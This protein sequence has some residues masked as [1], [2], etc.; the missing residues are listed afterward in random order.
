[1]KL[2][3]G[4]R[5][6]A[7]ACLLIGEGSIYLVPSKHKKKNGDVYFTLIPYV[8]FVNTDFEVIDFLEIFVRHFKPT[9]T[10]Y[11]V[12]EHIPLQANHKKS[13]ILSLH[14][15]HGVCSFLKKIRPY[16]FGIKAKEADL[17][18]EFCDSRLNR[19]YLKIGHPGQ[20]GNCCG[21]KPY[22][23]RELEIYKEL[24]ALNHRGREEKLYKEFVA[25]WLL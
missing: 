23:K 14:S 16:L 19:P 6:C 13:K 5:L 4:E 2:T 25:S 20:L 18:V 8:D 11:R 21:K 12:R 22:S 9:A 7:V 15:I 17:M 3:E 24:K 10:H 1:M